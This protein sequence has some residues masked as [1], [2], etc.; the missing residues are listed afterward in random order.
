MTN[1]GLAIKAAIDRGR[2]HQRLNPRKRI[3]FM[4]QWGGT[5]W[6]RTGVGNFAG[7]YDSPGLLIHASIADAE[8]EDRNCERMV[9]WEE[10]D[11]RAGE[12]VDL[13]DDCVRSSLGLCGP[14]LARTTPS[15]VMNVGL[16][17]KAAIDRGREHQ[18]LSP[19][20]LF[21]RFNMQWNGTLARGYDS[22]GLLIGARIAAH[23][24]TE[25]E[26]QE[27]NCDRMVPWEEL[28]TRA[29][30]LVALVD[31]CVAAVYAA[32]K[33]KAA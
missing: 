4:T 22:P 1:V 31:E 23:N 11:A 5:L 30:E 26:A 18:R 25:L 33:I 14:A 10:L 27:G 24:N 19:R 13:V 7:G 12:L 2:E 3:R 6:E 16:A 32:V 21:I 20:K 28:D 9:P 8:L 17:I 15:A 29:G